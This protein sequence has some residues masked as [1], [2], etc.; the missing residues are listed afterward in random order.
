MDQNSVG[1]CVAHGMACGIVAALSAKGIVLGSVPSQRRIYS[2]SLCLDRADAH[3]LTPAAKLPQ[4]EDLGT[5]VLTAVHVASQ[6]GVS[7]TQ[8]P[9]DGYNTDC[10][11]SNFSNEPTLLELEQES[12][13]L[14]VGAYEISTVGSQRILD[15]CLAL[16]AG[17]PVVFGTFV[18]TR[19]EAHDGSGVV[20]TQDPDDENGGG[21][22]MVC[23]G[24][25]TDPNG[26]RVFV[27]RNSWGTGWGMSG[28]FECTE[29]F[30]KQWWEAFVMDVRV[31]P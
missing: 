3:P 11:P 31:K 17:H 8:A 23:L 13:T 22:C 16:D 2:Q 12:T 6:W 28:D 30:V 25:R 1:S 21:H 4:L 26:S 14:I 24:Y 27:C 18:D 15:V 9:V 5:E 20:G 7:A 29:A 10:V 19:F